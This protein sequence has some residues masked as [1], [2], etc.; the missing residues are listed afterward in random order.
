MSEQYAVP[1][2]SVSSTTN[3]HIDGLTTPA[4][5]PTVRWWW[6]ESS[7]A[8][9]SSRSASSA[10]SARPS[11]SAAPISAPRIGPEAR[12]QASGGPACRNVPVSMP[13]TSLRG[14]HVDQVR[15]AGQH[16]AD[17]LGVGRGA[18]RGRP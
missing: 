18:A 9:R 14:A 10:S 1:P 12:S 13:R 16:A 5:G 4:I 11:N 17:G 7:G 6:Q 15:P 8:V 3:I 2:P